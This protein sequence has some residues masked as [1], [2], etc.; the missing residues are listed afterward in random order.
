MNGLHDGLQIRHEQGG[1]LWRLLMWPFAMVWRLVITVVKLVGRV[2]MLVSGMVMMIVGVLLTMTVIGAFV[3]I[4]LATLGF[5]L[6][7][8]SLF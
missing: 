1:N 6:I 3:G 8:R 5:L 4:P 2:A 7:L